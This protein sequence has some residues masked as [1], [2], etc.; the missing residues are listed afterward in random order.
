SRRSGS[1]RD[2][3]AE[4][5]TR[6]AVF[7][8]G[9]DAGLSGRAEIADRSE[10]R[11]GRGEGAPREE[12][13]SIADTVRSLSRRRS[14]DAHSAYRAMD[15]PSLRRSV[16]REVGARVDAKESGRWTGESR[17]LDSADRRRHDG[18]GGAAVGERDLGR[19]SP[20][21]RAYGGCT[22]RSLFAGWE[23]AGFGR[24]RQKSNRLGLRP[25]RDVKE[26][27]RPHGLDHL[28]RVLARQEVVHDR[29]LR[30]DGNRVGRRTVGEGGYA[31]RAS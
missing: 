6:R 31:A 13:R 23:V 1:H 29:E 3:G 12:R 27:R 18:A 2:E 28:G 7:V 16:A 25:A 21:R 22:A 24:R 8:G 5:E 15:D 17:A 11:K 20:A 26:I 19:T 9:R 14:E 30:P 10:K 4:E